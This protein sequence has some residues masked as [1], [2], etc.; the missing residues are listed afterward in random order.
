MSE[1]AAVLE[2]NS[3][4]KEVQGKKPVVGKKEG[5]CWHY[6]AEEA[7]GREDKGCSYQEPSGSKA[8]RKETHHRRKK[9]CA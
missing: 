5:G 3:G 4:E 1:G 2:A 8:R 6:K 7:F 9:A